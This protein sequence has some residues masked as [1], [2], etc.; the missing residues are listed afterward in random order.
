MRT[1]PADLADK[2]YA[3]SDEL[4]GE[5]PEV[6][7]A[8]VAKRVDIPRATLYYYFSGPDELR[9]F[10]MREKM[11]RTGARAWAAARGEGSVSDRLTALLA[12]QATSFSESPGLC[13]GLFEAFA[14]RGELGDVILDAGRHGMAPLRELLVEGRA[15]GELKVSDID[16]MAVALSG[17]LMMTCIVDLQ[18]GELDL[19]G[20]ASD[21]IEPLVEGLKA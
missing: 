11:E 20:L 1:P 3:A 14:R 4:L 16:R 7:V 6:G 9:A 10:L 21:V 17:A 12:A 18:R 5:G 13:M 2:L 15:T 19:D 8:E